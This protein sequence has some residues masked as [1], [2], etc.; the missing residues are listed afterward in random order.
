[1]II[2][3]VIAPCTEVLRSRVIVILILKVRTRKTMKVASCHHVLNIIV[4][5]VK[6]ITE[7]ISIVEIDNST[8]TAEGESNAGCSSRGLN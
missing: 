6:S 2:L 5:A 3:K 8:A 4:K 1:M 7:E